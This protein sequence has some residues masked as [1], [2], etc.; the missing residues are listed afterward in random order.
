M[1]PLR[2][3][4]DPLDGRFFRQ[5]TFMYRAYCIFTNLKMLYI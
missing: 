1:A 3:I 5:G 4:M 2:Q